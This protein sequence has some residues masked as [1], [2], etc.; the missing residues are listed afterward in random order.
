LRGAANEDIARLLQQ[1]YLTRSDY[2]A[3]SF[4][5]LSRAKE[6]LGARNTIRK[7]RMVPRPRDECQSA[8]PCVD[9]ND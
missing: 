5:L 6:Q 4:S 8:V 3:V 7:S 2:R 1:D 9:Y